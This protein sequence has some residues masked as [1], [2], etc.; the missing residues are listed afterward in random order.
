MAYIPKTAL[1]A[2]Y[3]HVVMLLPRPAIVSQRAPLLVALSFAWTTP[4]RG[5]PLLA[6][7]GSKIPQMGGSLVPNC[8]PL[9][10]RVMHHP[11]A[12]RGCRPPLARPQTRP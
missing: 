10:A 2:N 9:H 11:P 8:A 4:A 6:A 7:D 3:I 1:S 5:Q 12:S